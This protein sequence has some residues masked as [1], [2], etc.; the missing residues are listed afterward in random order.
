MPSWFRKPSLESPLIDIHSHCIPQIDDGAKSLDDSIEMIQGF[1]TLGYQKAVTTPHIH[2]NYPNTNERIL[3]GLLLLQNELKARSIAFELE[4]AAEYF[5]DEIFFDSV[6]SN[7]P[8][9]S[10][11]SKYVLVESSFVNK[12]LL[13]EP[14]LF[15]L[16][17]KGYQPILAHPERYKF[18][19]GELDWLYQLKEMGTLFQVT[20]SSFAGYYGPTARGIA[21]ELSKKNMIDFLG[22]DL[23]HPQQLKYLEEGLSKNDVRTLCES[24][25]LMNKT[26]L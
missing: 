6:K 15:E 5:V 7:Q 24:S 4:A 16:K 14:C 23:H 25:K 22:S 17:S 13:F 9:L 11:G 8:I 12:P 21:N 18:L 3:E 19:E 10:F 20:V 2:P 26:L 1:K